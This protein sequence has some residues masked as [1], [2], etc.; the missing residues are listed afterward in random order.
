MDKTVRNPFR[1]SDKHPADARD[2]N[3]ELM[4]VLQE[5]I[6]LREEMTVVQE[7]SRQSVTTSY[8]ALGV[9]GAGLGFIIENNLQAIFLVFPFLLYGLAWSVVRYTLAVLN[10]S[11]HL[12]E[13]NIPRIRELLAL[14]DSRQDYSMVLSWET[15]GKGVLRRYGWWAL[16]VAGAHYGVI[17]LGGAL[18]FVAY[19][20]FPPNP[21]LL[22]WV[23]YALIAANIAA[24]IYSIFIGFKTELSR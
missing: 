19:F 3:P 14:E 23:L 12:R 13:H 16:P 22:D 9:L 15:H 1:P 11:M 21:P 18:S 4:V 7:F 10:M 24:L 5:Y 2:T 6:A 8:V 17:L 20:V